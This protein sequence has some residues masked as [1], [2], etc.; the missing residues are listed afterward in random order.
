[1]RK[2]FFNYIPFFYQRAS[3]YN[4]D[5]D[6]RA[7]SSALKNSTTNSTQSYLTK[8]KLQELRQVERERVELVKRRQLG[9]DISSNLGVRMDGDPGDE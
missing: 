7:H 9:L 8:E 5:A 1:M 3:S 4:F 2:F 6:Y